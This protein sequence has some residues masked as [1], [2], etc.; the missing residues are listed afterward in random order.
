MA[1]VSIKLEKIFF[2]TLDD[3]AIKI[4]SLG[5]D[6]FVWIQYGPSEGGQMIEVMKEYTR[7]EIMSMVHFFEPYGSLEATE[8][9]EKFIN[10]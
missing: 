4:I 6:Q 8:L 1:H 10:S 3:V 7:D 5:Y 2:Y 9:F